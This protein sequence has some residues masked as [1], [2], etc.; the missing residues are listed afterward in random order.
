MGHHW[1][2]AGL[3]GVTYLAT[4]WTPLA[5]PLLANLIAGS[6]APFGFVVDPQG[7]AR[8]MNFWDA[9]C[10]L[11]AQL[12]QLLQGAPLRVVADAY[13]AKAP[14]INWMLS[15]K[16]LGVYV[17]TRMR[18]DAVGWDDPL[19]SDRKRP[20]PKSPKPPKGHK[21]PLASLL[22]ALPLQ[23]VAVFIYG[24][25]HTLQ[26]VTR[27]VSAQKVR[28]VVIKAAAK[29]VILLSTDLTLCPELIIQLYALRFASE[30]AIRD[31]KQHCGL[32]DYQCTSLTAMMRFVSLSLI[33]YCLGRLSLLTQW[34]ADWLEGPETTAPLSWSR[35]SR[36]VRR[37]VLGQ[38]FHKSASSADFQN[39]PATA[40]LLIRLVA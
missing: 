13:F 39:P 36:A 9:V 25:L 2:L 26:I 14:F 33:S 31:T 30:L 6:A 24:R 19:P 38:V 29:P 34:Q 40:D 7:V 37:F 23:S 11:I 5:W 27:D 4:K 21:W 1:A 18:W 17:I 3:L 32:G 20:G 10:P 35:L 12:H 22:R 8:A 28:V 15:V 16:P